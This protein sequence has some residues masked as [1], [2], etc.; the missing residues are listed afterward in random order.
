MDEWSL[1]TGNAVGL[2]CLGFGLKILILR[3]ARLQI[4]QSMGEL[5]KAN[6]VKL[7]KG[8]TKIPT[9]KGHNRGGV[10]GKIKYIL[11]YKN[12]AIPL[13]STETVGG[14]FIAHILKPYYWCLQNMSKSEKISLEASEYIHGN[15]NKV[16]DQLITEK[17]NFQLIM[18][19]PPYNMDKEYEKSQSLENYKE[20]IETV[21]SKLVKLLHKR[22]SIC[23]QVGNYI[24]PKTKEVVPLD[25]FYHDLFKKSGLL[26]RNRIIWHFEHG[27]HANRRFSGRYETIMWYTHDGEY[28]FNL[29]D[30]RVPS[31]YPGK[32]YY[33]GIKKG[34]ISGNP[35]GKNPSDVWKIVSNDWDNEIW[36]IPNVKANHIEKT[37]H[38]CQFPVALAQRLIRALCPTDGLVVDPYVGSG[39]S[40]VAAL[41][42]GRR[43]SGSDINQKYIDVAKDR[44][45]LWE[46]GRLKI[47]PIELPILTP[48]ANHSVS[49]VPEEW[50]TREATDG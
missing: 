38:P 15:A 26:L 16:L 9:L 47:R 46:E 20:E 44:L 27:L 33:K 10:V 14:R 7:F 28:T 24:N 30:V 39:S 17:R 23:W 12:N 22:G 43:F 40:A 25:I 49:K 18:T 11:L 50:R 6:V 13:F 42:E 45:R 34:Q 3:I 19:S 21:I 48:P 35:K 4:R 32:T 1:S 37:D 31:K 8:K 5:R 36:E 2:R 29:D 41:I